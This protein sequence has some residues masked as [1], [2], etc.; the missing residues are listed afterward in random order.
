MKERDRIRQ[1]L[2]KWFLCEPLL[3][4]AW[5][6]HALVMEPR[7]ATIRV[8]AGHIEYNPEFIRALNARQLESVLHFEALRILLKHPYSRR[9]EDARRTYAA[10]NITVQE[11]LRTDLPF[12]TARE[13]F[14]SDEFD[15]QYLEFYY[16]KLEQ[17][18]DASSASS[19]EQGQG[20]GE[21]GGV[22][23]LEDASFGNGG[24]GGGGEEE[25]SIPPSLE[26]YAD[27][28]QTA[29]ENVE[30]WGPDDF[31]S[32]R[33]DEAIHTARET[34]A[35]GSIAGRV[36]EAILATLRPRLDY[37]AVLRQFR[38]SILSTRRT[39]TRMKPNRRYG[40][41][42]LGSRRDFVTRL[43]V[44]VDVSGSMSSRELT[45]GFSMINQFF[46]YGVPV[47]DVIQF[48]TEI[49]DAVLTLKKARHEVRVLGRGGT[50]FSPVMAY[51]DSHREYDGLIIFTDGYAA[52]PAPSKNRRT[53]ILWLF[54]HEANYRRMYPSLKHLGG[55][56]F[57]RADAGMQ[58]TR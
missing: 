42:Y 25:T 47:I 17:Q 40:F 44:A 45:Q 46:K 4:S 32:E 11:Y 55:G 54:N 16:S 36:R 8:R 28:E 26:A 52:V 49:K 7:I 15:R 48:D 41:Q 12:P 53:R 35:W 34:N 30:A 19:P 13:V 31:L 2:E 50:D 20:A 57:I 9:R 23:D 29:Q 6:T 14:G 37:R 56:A 18:T 1:T 39:L 3:F 43:L 10:S 38:T 58:E 51:L 24:G 22:G 33:L 27:P 21:A 5:T